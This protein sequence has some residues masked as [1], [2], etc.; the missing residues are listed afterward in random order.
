M[1]TTIDT[2]KIYERLKDA[3]LS[4]KAAKE[5]AEVIKETTD[6]SS[7]MKT[8]IKEE[9][10]KD[11]ATEGNLQLVETRLSGEITKVETRLSGEMK[12]LKSDLEWKMKL[13]FLV[14]AF[15]IILSNPRALDLIS[16]LLGI[17]K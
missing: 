15:L 4:E 7:G 11:L 14:L 2:L 10:S 13:Y 16:K 5:I 1:A 12:V 17:V 8:E 6:F 9:L 3:E